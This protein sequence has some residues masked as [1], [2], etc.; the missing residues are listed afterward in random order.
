MPD[1]KKKRK[2]LVDSVTYTYMRKV[3]KWMFCPN[4][5]EGKM[6]IDKKSTVWICVDCGY[7]LSADEFEDNYVF[8]FCDNCDN[9]DEYL[10]NQ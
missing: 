5:H 3:K 6:T 4:C 9:C 8:W 1:N 7:Q 10:N 2:S